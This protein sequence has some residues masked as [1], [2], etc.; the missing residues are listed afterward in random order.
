MQLFLISFIYAREHPVE[1]SIMRTSNLLENLLPLSDDLYDVY[2][3]ILALIKIFA[4]KLA[5]GTLFP[6]VLISNIS[7]VFFFFF[8]S[9]YHSRS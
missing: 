2:S 4:A 8:T 1:S 7:S 6:F 5:A 9:L 3:L